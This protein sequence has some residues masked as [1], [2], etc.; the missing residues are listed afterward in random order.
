MEW[1]REM[2]QKRIRQKQEKKLDR[3]T[4]GHIAKQLSIPLEKPV[5]RAKALSSTSLS[6]VTLTKSIDEKNK[7][8]QIVSV[9]FLSSLCMQ[10]MRTSHHSF[11]TGFIDRGVSQT[12]AR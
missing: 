3:Q 1:K 10:H 12:T 8:E 7:R 4:E 6:L 9:Y 5:C 2:A 11:S